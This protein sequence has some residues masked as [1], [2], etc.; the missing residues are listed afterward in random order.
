MKFKTSPLEGLHLDLHPKQQPTVSVESAGTSA[1]SPSRDQQVPWRRSV[2]EKWTN[3]HISPRITNS[4]LKAESG[5]NA[6]KTNLK[7]DAGIKP[8]VGLQSLIVSIVRSSLNVTYAVTYAQSI[9]DVVL[10][11]SILRG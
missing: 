10:T 2:E 7:D 3:P 11:F 6:A 9:E 5:R 4:H 8:N 1:I